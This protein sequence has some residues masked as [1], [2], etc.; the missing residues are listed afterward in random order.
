MS[1]PL[2]FAIDTRVSI[3]YAAYALI[4][5][6]RPFIAEVSES[7]SE[8]RNLETSVALAAARHPEAAELFNIEY[9][10]VHTSFSL[11]KEHLFCDW[12]PYKLLLTNSG[13]AWE[14]DL[15]L[16]AHKCRQ[17]KILLEGCSSGTFTQE[18]LEQMLDTEFSN[19]LHFLLDLKLVVNQPPSTSSFRMTD[20]PA[21]YRLQHASVLFRTN[22]TGILVDPHLH[23]LCSTGIESD[24]YRHQLEKHVDMILITHFHEDHWSLSTLLLF[25]RDT[26]I[27][28]PQVPTST[29]IC[30]DMVALLKKYGFTKVIS[31]PWYSPAIRLDDCEIHVLP[32]YGEQPTRYDSA[33]HRA[34]RNWGNT[35]V[36]RSEDY[37]AWLLV[38]SGADQQG[39]MI[40]V[41]KHVTESIGKVDAIL[42][43]LRRF[44][45]RNAFY[46]NGGFNWLTLSPDQLL[47]FDA[48]KDHLLTLGPEGVAKICDAVDAR[49]FL[50]YAHWWSNL[51]SRPEGDQDEESL[52][53]EFA[54]CKRRKTKIVR[55]NIGDS[56]SPNDR[57]SN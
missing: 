3:E 26:P 4:A 22:S 18:R 53:A 56:F 10:N 16:E 11:L 27:V 14:V 37:T 24:I 36:V 45:I 2:A 42:G 33:K 32:F 40:D 21:I 5:K 35:Y 38:D 49:Y 44:A 19:L 51:G 20:S 9:G 28:V 23:T 17:L 34:L 6:V 43:N 55:W 15:D 29:I 52:L 7:I 47:A 50:P 48:M 30:G 57:A 46:I 31:I 12:E 8:S 1:K 41:A 54:T 25:P 39:S 13:R